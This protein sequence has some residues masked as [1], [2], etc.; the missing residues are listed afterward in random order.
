VVAIAPGAKA[1]NAMINVHSIALTETYSNQPTN[2]NQHSQAIRERC[3]QFTIAVTTEMAPA[4]LMMRAKG[5][6]CSEAEAQSKSD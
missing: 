1:Q 6:S 2:Y 3:N 5:S 4:A